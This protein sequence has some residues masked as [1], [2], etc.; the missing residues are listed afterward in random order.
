MYIEKGSENKIIFDEDSYTVSPLKSTDTDPTNIKDW[1]CCT[2][3][4]KGLAHPRSL[5][6]MRDLELIFPQILRENCGKFLKI[7]SN[8]LK[9]SWQCGLCVSQEYIY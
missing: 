3:L 1:L 4:C 7:S 5:V 8:E 6:S 9:I 2:I